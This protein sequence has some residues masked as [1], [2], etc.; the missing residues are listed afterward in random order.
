[1]LYHGRSPLI[2]GGQPDVPVNTRP[3]TSGLGV[4]FASVSSDM[5]IK[6]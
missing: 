2:L 3:A 5:A 4:R 1:M 6:L